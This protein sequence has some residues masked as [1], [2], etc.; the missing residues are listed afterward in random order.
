MQRRSRSGDAKVVG[1]KAAFEYTR[2]GEEG[3]EVDAGHNSLHDAA[4]DQIRQALINGRFKPGQTFTIRTLASVL[5]TSPMPVRDALKR[6]VAERAL[7]LRPNR[8]V[9]LPYMSRARF[10]E[11]LQIRLALEPMLAARATPHIGPEQIS[12][13]AEDHETMCKAVEQRDV[14]TY[15]AAN[16]RFHFLLYEAASTVVM[17]PVVESMWMQI[18]PYL[19]EVFAAKETGTVTADHHHIAV[20]RA[21]RRQDGAAASRAIWEDISDAADGILKGNLF[22]E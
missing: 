22:T 16:R 17:L 10:Q 12:A 8:S 15:L 1:L 7:E 3:S 5:G 18:G 2:E 21:L 20:L 11:I 6:L 13:M 4:Y 9:I 19:H 14:T